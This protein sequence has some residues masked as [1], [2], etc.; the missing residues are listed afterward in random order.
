MSFNYTAHMSL[1]ENFSIKDKLQMKIFTER[2]SSGPKSTRIIVRDHDTGEVY[3]DLHNKILISGAQV[4]ACKLFGIDPTVNFPN[5]NEEFGLQNTLD[6]E[7]VQPYNEP[8]I[9][10]FG[11][12]NGGC[13]TTQ[14]DVFPVRYTE[15]IE[16]ENLI[17]FRYVDPE[18]DLAKD[19]RRRYHGRYIDEDGMIRYM[20]KSFD[21][22]PQLHLRYLDGT[23]ITSS[24]YSI[25]SSQNAECYVEMRLRLTRQDLRDY[26]EKVVGWNE[27]LINSLTLLYAW[28]DNTVDEY[29]WYQQI[30]PF[31]KLNFPTEWLV[32]LTKAID[33]NYQVFF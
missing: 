25:D 6:Y 21:T 27:A 33:F 26:F 9:C 11:L 12:G 13:G 4:T 32:D 24:I 17:P 19:I 18:N 16:P 8:I 31:S 14:S 30:L 20:F 15:R 5:Y 3:G 10:L 7:T 22:E 29:I 1:R 23:Q 28:Y 2:I